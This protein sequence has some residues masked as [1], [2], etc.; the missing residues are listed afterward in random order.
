MPSRNPSVGGESIDHHERTVQNNFLFASVHEILIAELTTP[1]VRARLAIWEVRPSGVGGRLAPLLSCVFLCP[2]LKSWWSPFS[3]FPFYPKTLSHVLIRVERTARQRQDH[4]RVEAGRRPCALPPPAW[5]RH[6][7]GA[8]P[9]RCR[10]LGLGS[11][12]SR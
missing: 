12:V 3:L 9:R 5:L 4:G 7:G 10:G 11:C 2:L 6:G 8:W 1:G